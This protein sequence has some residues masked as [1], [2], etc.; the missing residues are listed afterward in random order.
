[1]VLSPDY[2]GPGAAGT[3]AGRRTQRKIRNTTPRPS[4]N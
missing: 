1:M 4:W 3:R 2:I